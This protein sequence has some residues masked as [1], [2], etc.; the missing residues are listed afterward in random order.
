MQTRAETLEHP[1]KGAGRVQGGRKP[2]PKAKPARAKA[3]SSG[4]LW[5]QV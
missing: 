1:P 3:K 2:N 4:A 5:T